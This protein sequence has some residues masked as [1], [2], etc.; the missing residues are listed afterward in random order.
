MPS[1]SLPDSNNTISATDAGA[2]AGTSTN[3]VIKPK[4][5]GAAHTRATKRTIASKATRASAAPHKPAKASNAV[6]RLE[7]SEVAG[8][9]KDLAQS[10][11]SILDR[12]AT[13]DEEDEESDFRDEEEQGEDEA[14]EDNASQSSGPH[15]DSIII[16]YEVPAGNRTC[17][18]NVPSNFSFAEHRRTIAST[19]GYT[20]SNQIENIE[21]AWKLSTAKKSDLPAELASEKDLKKMTSAYRIAVEK[22]EKKHATYKDKVKK[23]TI[24]PGTK[25]PAQVDVVVVISD[26]GA[27]D[28]KRGKGKETS[29][30]PDAAP[31]TT[32]P[33]T[34]FYKRLHAAYPCAT[35]PRAIC[36][37]TAAGKPVHATPNDVDTWE[38]LEK[39]DPER[40]SVESGQIPPELKLY[41][42]L[43]RRP[44]RVVATPGNPASSSQTPAQ[45]GGSSPQLHPTTG[46]GIFPASQPSAFSGFNP[47]LILATAAL[48]PFARMA[49]GY[50]NTTLFPSSFDA[51]PSPV[52]AEISVDYPPITDW[53]G[54][55]VDGNPK[56]VRDGQ[57]YSIFGEKFTQAGFFRIDELVN[58]KHV[59]VETLKMLGI[60]VGYASNILSWAEVDVAKAQQDARRAKRAGF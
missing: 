36:F 49:L 26:I 10:V 27:A 14:Q 55:A 58:R 39:Q 33:N 9:T 48:N 42:A 29:A 1:V 47:N 7:A 2:S 3:Q 18:T 31:L 40:Y 38:A 11:N 12:F 16:E 20:G 17:T 35:D 8:G 53:L 52:K 28:K 57:S 50:T 30:D 54:D 22:E 6:H 4:K 43:G 44:A 25:V 46:F 41:D 13:S 56:R 32:K 19:M 59:T 23:G 15:E 34:S 21:L 45:I 51:P 5:G 24:K 37:L 60:E